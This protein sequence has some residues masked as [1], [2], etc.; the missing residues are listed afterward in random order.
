[1]IPPE[2]LAQAITPYINQAKELFQKIDQGNIKEAAKLDIAKDLTKEEFV[3]LM[4]KNDMERMPGYKEMTPEAQQAKLEEEIEQY[5]KGWGEQFDRLQKSLPKETTVKAQVET[6]VKAETTPL[7]AKTTPEK[8]VPQDL[9][10]E[11]RKYKTAEEFVNNQKILYHGTNQDFQ[12]FDLSKR[13]TGADAL[14]VGIGDYGNGIYFTRDIN[15]AKNYASGMSEKFG[16][17]PSV[18]EVHLDIKNPFDMN[19]IG[20]VDTLIMR[21]A[22]ESA[23]LKKIGVSKKGFNLYKDISGDLEDNWGD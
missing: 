15:T 22:G 19:K 7:E 10:E 2:I 16:G 6:P 11:A 14:G 21:G 17:K 20:E 9:M 5:G 3:E 18:K 4:V 12:E 13:G 8:A 23:A 1:M